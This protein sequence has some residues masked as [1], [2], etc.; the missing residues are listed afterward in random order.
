MHVST[1]HWPY[2]VLMWALVLAGV[3]MLI[4]WV[5]SVYTYGIEV[6]ERALAPAVRGVDVALFAA[7]IGC[8]LAAIIIPIVRNR[9]IRAA[10]TVSPA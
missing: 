9:R 3:G 8:L 6:D 4:G 2:R 1:S 10:S 5:F 7:G